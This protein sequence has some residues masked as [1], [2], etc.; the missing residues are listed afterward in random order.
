VAEKLNA[1]SGFKASGVRLHFIGDYYAKAHA[2]Q[3]N[4]LADTLKIMPRSAIGS[5]ANIMDT[6]ELMYIHPELV[7]TDRYDIANQANGVSGDPSKS[8]KEIGKHLLD[9]KI[10]LALAQIK[11]SLE[12]PR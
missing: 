12:A 8:S 4:W 9:I 11:Q 3:Q 10:R 7:H 2:E 6:S 5:H 1:D